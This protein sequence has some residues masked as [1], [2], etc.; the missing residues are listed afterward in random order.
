M[1][2]DIVHL[3]DDLWNALDSNTPTNFMRNDVIDIVAEVP[4]ANDEFTWWW[5]LQLKDGQFALLAALCDYT[6]WDCQSCIVT[7]KICTTAMQCAE[8]APEKDSDRT[9]RANL[10]GQLTGKYPK[11]TYWE[12]EVQ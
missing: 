10:I 3:N 5:I 9:I 4:G 12:T 8:T 1:I 7:E 11:F 2:E 6:G